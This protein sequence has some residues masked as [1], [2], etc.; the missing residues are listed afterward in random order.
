MGFINCI[1]RP[2]LPAGLLAAIRHR[3]VGVRKDGKRGWVIFDLMLNL[4]RADGGPTVRPT[5]WKCM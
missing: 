3:S 4:S 2:H 1:I 5:K